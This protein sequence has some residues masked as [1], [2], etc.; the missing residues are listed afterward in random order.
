LNAGW[1]TEKGRRQPTVNCAK[2]GASLSS[3]AAF[4]SSCGAP[5]GAGAGTGVGTGTGTTQPAAASSLELPGI[6]FNVAGLLCYIL[7]PVA[8]IIFLLVGPYNRN[9]FVRF[10]AFQALFLGLAGI[11][12]AIALRILTSILALIPVLGWIVGALAWFVYTITLLVLVIL[13]MYK[14]YNG[15]QYSLLVIG[16]LAAQQGEKT[17]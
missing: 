13:L 8:C 1:F 4:C 7:W 16:S 11:L 10:H 15:E 17:Q 9:K 12:V 6:G 14:A 5:A 2:C 3:D